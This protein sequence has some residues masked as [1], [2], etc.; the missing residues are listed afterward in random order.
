ME[1]DFKIT[2]DSF[3][4]KRLDGIITNQPVDLTEQHIEIVAEAI[5]QVL[6]NLGINS[7]VEFNYDLRIK[8]GTSFFV[9]GSDVTILPPNGET[10]TRRIRNNSA[11]I[12][13]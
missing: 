2:I 13:K 10:Y 4:G 12:K 6:Y 1:R 9:H 3:S 5:M 8:D 7:N 11:I